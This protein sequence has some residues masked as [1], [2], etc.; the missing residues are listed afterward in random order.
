MHNKLPFPGC[1][2]GSHTAVIS[3]PSLKELWELLFYVSCPAGKAAIPSPN[4]NPHSSLGWPQ[5]S[6][7]AGLGCWEL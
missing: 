4:Y 6:V 2:E 5:Q 7:E 3:G 1:P